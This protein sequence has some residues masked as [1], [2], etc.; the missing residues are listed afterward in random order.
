MHI[1]NVDDE[2]MIRKGLHKMLES[3]PSRIDRIDLAENGEHA[4]NQMLCFFNL[5]N[6]N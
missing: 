5:F 4:I 6:R 3:Y 1:L 2:P